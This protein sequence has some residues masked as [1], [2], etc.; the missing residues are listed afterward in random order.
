M[1][2]RKRTTR[3][4]KVSESTAVYTAGTRERAEWLTS[5]EAAERIGVSLRTVQAWRK[6]G[7]LAGR[8]VGGRLRFSDRDIERFLDEAE[9]DVFYH[10]RDLVFD[11]LWDNED[12]AI[13]DT[14]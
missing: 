4:Q 1:K 14:L 7:R 12:D 11:E 6:S 9:E 13:Y 3:K 2:R 10:A 5:R 8:K